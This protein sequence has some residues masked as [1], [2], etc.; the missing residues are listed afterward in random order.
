MKLSRLILSVFVAAAPTV[1]SVAQEPRP[2]REPSIEFRDADGQIVYR[3]AQSDASDADS[4]QR[5]LWIAQ[6]FERFASRSDEEGMARMQ[7]RWAGLRGGTG[8]SMGVPAGSAIVAPA[9]RATEG[10]YV[11]KGDFSAVF[12]SGTFVMFGR[13][14]SGASSGGATM[15]GTTMGGA[16]MGAATTSASGG[17][18]SDSEGPARVPGEIARAELVEG[19]FTLTGEIG[20]VQQVYFYVLDAITHGGARMAPTKGQ[21]FILEPGELG[22]TMDDNHKPSMAGGYFNDGVYGSWKNSRAYLELQA[23]LSLAYRRVEGESESERDRFFAIGSA[24]QNAL[25]DTETAGRKEAALNHPDLLV[26]QLVLET[27]WLGGDWMLDAAR[28]IVA[29]DPEN[30]Y[31]NAF[32]ERAEARAEQRG[33]SREA[34]AIGSRYLPFAAESLAGDK[35]SLSEVCQQ[36][37]YVLLEFWASWCGPCRAEVPHIKQAYARFQDQG[38]EVFG[39]T[40]DDD[41]S[42]WARASEE[43]GLPWINTGFGAKSDPVLLYAVSGVPA[44][45]LIDGETGRVVARNLRGDALEEK[46]EMLFDGQGR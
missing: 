23:L 32:V 38:F 12:A 36:N 29:L 8:P 25:L 6:L 27:T 26:R 21:G 14:E 7:N 45:Y 46:L 17:G 28:G 2:I 5:A 43:E 1:P 33:R 24:V 11:L 39:Y 44:N 16:T 35:T 41:R 13:E 42:A 9:A 31:A 10:D 3:L 20:E 18:A 40:L 30:A 34:G 37:R 4:M 15:G 22:L 19:R